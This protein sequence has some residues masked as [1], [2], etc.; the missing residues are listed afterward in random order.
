MLRLSSARLL[1]QNECFA[2]FN[3]HSN[4]HMDGRGE[5]YSRHI[6][7]KEKF[8]PKYRELCKLNP[9]IYII[10]VRPLYIRS[11]E[12]NKKSIR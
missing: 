12:L 9:L 11:K 2:F 8:S 1:A 10:K 6:D 5:R 4:A 3:G 7:R